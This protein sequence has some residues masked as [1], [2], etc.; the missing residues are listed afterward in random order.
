MLGLDSN[1][2]FR[3]T[4]NILFF[5]ILFGIAFFFATYHLTESP[6][7]WYDEGIY[8]QL[9]ANMAEGYGASFQ[10]APGHI[11][12]VPKFT[13][14]YAFIYPL[15]ATMYFFGDSVL[16]ARSFMVVCILGLF[17][18]AFFLIRKRSGATTTLFALALLVT[19]PPVYGNGKSVLGEVPALLLLALS[20]SNFQ[21]ALSSQ[22]YSKLGLILA[23]TFAGLAAAAK[24]LFL[25]FLPAFA[26]IVL[27]EWYRGK[28]SRQD[29][30]LAGLFSSLPVAIWMFVQYRSAPSFSEM[31]TFYA[32]PY[33]VQNLF[34]V[35]KDNLINFFTE[36]GPLYLL[37][38][39]LTWVIALLIR[40]KRGIAIPAEESMAFVFSI[41]VILSYL[42]ITGWHRYLFPAQIMALLYFIPSLSYS[43]RW[44]SEKF[45]VKLPVISLWFQKLCVPVAVAL[46]L[47]YGTYGVLFDSWVATAYQ[48]DKTAFWEQYFNNIPSDT[49]FFFYDAP[50]VALFMPHRNYYQYLELGGGPFGSEWLAVIDEGEVDR[51]I[52]RTDFLDEKKEFFL[53]R[54]SPKSTAY[55][56]TVLEQLP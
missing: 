19:F 15:A 50:E 5:A 52:V 17:G 23:G 4:Q 11:E 20:L 41:L 26:L 21:W 36:A 24:L 48:S 54:Y 25:L 13:V 34:A 6:S 51:I 30:A 40:K 31:L 39:V 46:L 27:L 3:P 43:I 49:S 2:G 18:T 55:K 14:G 1:M 32:N 16:V 47:L 44:F 53:K 56:Y 8:I 7:V 45:A 38:L 22:K 10:F 29:V 42:R 12:E 37:L 9:A 35:V 33:G 28:L